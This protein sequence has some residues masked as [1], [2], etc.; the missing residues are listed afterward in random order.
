M[1]ARFLAGQPDAA[2]AVAAALQL[3]PSDAAMRE[4]AS[5][6]FQVS[7]DQYSVPV[8][9]LPGNHRGCSRFEWRGQMALLP[10]PAA[11]FLALS[12]ACERLTIA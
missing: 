3:L 9:M 1:V 8:R 2:A 12:L 4:R 6:Q 11:T 7:L 5:A 10:R